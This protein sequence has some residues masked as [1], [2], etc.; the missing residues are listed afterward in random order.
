M[1]APDIVINNNK[2]G[3]GTLQFLRNFHEQVSGLNATMT[4]NAVEGAGDIRFALSSGGRNLWNKLVVNEHAIF[5]NDGPAADN[6]LGKVLASYVADAITLNGGTLQAH[7]NNT[8]NVSENRGIT[9]GEHGGTLWGLTD[10]RHWSVDSIITGSGS[11]TVGRP[12]GVGASGNVT[13]NAANT[14]NGN[15]TV[16]GGSLILG[17]SGSIDDSPV[18]DVG[19]GATF[20]VSAVSGYTVGASQ[21]LTGSGTIKGATTI[22]GTLAPGASPGTLT[23][24][25]ALTLAGSTIMQIDG[26]AGAGVTAGHDFVNLTGTGGD[27]LLT[28]GGAMTLDIGTT[29]GVGTYSWDL[30]DFASVAGTFTGITLA[31]QYSGSLTDAGGGVWGQADGDNTWSFTE[32]DGV[33]GLT[34]IPEPSATLLGGL[35]L[36]ALLLRRRR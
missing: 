8:Y 21:T 3:G 36:L 11:L 34:V 22:A 30:F 9:L 33:L 35:G 25:N 20:D 10:Q 7:G 2:V 1:M 31:G 13:L 26:N 28:Y 4:L 12:I 15:T 32:S 6:A 17:A 19:S 24:E 29:F 5:S 23:F 27:G 16:A 14:Y 18:I